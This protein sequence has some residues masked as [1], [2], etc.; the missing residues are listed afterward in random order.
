M[1]KLKVLKVTDKSERCDL[2]QGGPVE[3]CVCLQVMSK[4][5]DECKWGDGG[6]LWEHRGRLMG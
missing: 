1:L 6:A 5:R 4:E 2:Q 3:V